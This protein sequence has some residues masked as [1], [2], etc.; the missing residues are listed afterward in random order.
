MKRTASLLLVIATAFSVVAAMAETSS[1]TNEPPAKLIP[2]PDL[3]AQG[4]V[5]ITWQAENVAIGPMSGK[6]ALNQSPRVGH[7]HIHVDDLPWLWAHMSTTPIRCGPLAARAAQDPD[8]IG[9]R[10]SSGRSRSVQDSDVHNT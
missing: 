6:E 3:L 8:R 2:A 10:H 7:L 9:K 1:P 4:I 5:W